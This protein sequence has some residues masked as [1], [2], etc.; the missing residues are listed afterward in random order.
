MPRKKRELSGF[1]VFQ[2][3][4]EAPQGSVVTSGDRTFYD[5]GSQRKAAHDAWEAL[6]TTER[7]RYDEL[8]RVRN[9]ERA[10]ELDNRG[11]EEDIGS[12][13]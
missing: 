9:N 8:A 2:G 7:V 10:E 12:A 4:E 3:S 1:D 11:G 6:P 13:S 5:I